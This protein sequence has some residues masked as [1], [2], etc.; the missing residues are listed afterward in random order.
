MTYMFH[1]TGE[2][3]RTIRKSLNVSQE[4]W[5]EIVGVNRVA[6]SDW[7]RDKYPI[8]TAVELLLHE[9]KRE[10]EMLFRLERYRGIRE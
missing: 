1:M 3:H 2:E 6:V 7:E 4:R 8:P 5:G 10:P 9:L